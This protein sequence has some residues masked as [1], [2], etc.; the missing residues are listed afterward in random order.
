MKTKVFCVGLN[1]TGTSSLYVASKM[2]GLKSVHWKDDNG[3]NI[4]TRIEENF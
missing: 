4:K 3:I 1:K 2:L